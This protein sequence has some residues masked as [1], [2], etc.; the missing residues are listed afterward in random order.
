MQFM[1]Y[2]LKDGLVVIS[3]LLFFGC[4]MNKPPLVQAQDAPTEKSP[5]KKIPIVQKLRQNDHLPVEERIKLYHQL[6]KEAPQLYNFEDETE[7]TMYGYS[8][9]WANKTTEAIEV[10]KLIATEFPNSS[11]AYDNLGEGYLKN[12][13][14]ELALLNYERSL[15]MDPENFNAE[16]QVANI[17]FPDRVPLQPAELFKKVYPATAYRDDLDQLGTTLLKVHPNALKFITREAFWKSIEDK[18]RQITDRTTYG[19]FAWY[20][21]EIIANVHCSHT[22]MGSFDYEA[23]MLPESARFPLQ[24]RWIS[25]QLF[26]IDPLSNSQKVKIK[27]EVVSINGTKVA[28]IIKECYKHIPAQGYIETTKNHFFNTWSTAM[29]PFALGFPD[30]YEIVIKGTNAPI[31]LNTSANIEEPYFDRTLD[32]SGNNLS[33]SF[34]EGNTIA[35][36]KVA[37]FNYYRWAD[38]EVFKAFIDSSFSEIR[39][40]DVK[41]LVIDLRQNRGGSQSSSI[42]LLQYLVNQPFTYYSN[43]QFEGKRDKIEGEDIVYPF[44]NRFDGKTCFIIDGV[45]NSTTGH[46]MSIARYL[47]LGTIVGEELGSN[48]FC[49]AGMTTKRLANTKLVYYVANNTHESLAI[50]LPDETGILPDYTVT[51]GIEDFLIK[52][53]TVKAFAIQLAKQ[54]K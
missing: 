11:N 33:L 47:K 36:L 5:P 53:D 35:F 50:D 26:V 44:T 4:G 22:N 17:R 41:N 8:I 14:K 34:I 38:F 19:A 23:A 9:L 13:N 52:R 39:K 40:K 28:E 45:G 46:F 54:N 42:H 24:T 30:R 27:D 3:C 16:D 15:A 25:N 12:G 18:K 1:N 31:I 48:Q 43:A 6:K 32:L 37:S 10:F 20:C 2:T 51:Q 7:L 29:I 21:S 49:S